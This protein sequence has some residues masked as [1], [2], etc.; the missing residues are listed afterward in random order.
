MTLTLWCISSDHLDAV[1]I[2][3]NELKMIL[4]IRILGSRNY[5][6]CPLL[7]RIIATPKA[8]QIIRNDGLQFRHRLHFEQS[9]AK[10]HS[11]RTGA[12][13]NTPV[14]CSPLPLWG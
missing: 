9:P 13:P 11:Y 10:L 7:H 2:C 1:H 12:T 8:F 5:L 3:L 6:L 14:C 4:Q